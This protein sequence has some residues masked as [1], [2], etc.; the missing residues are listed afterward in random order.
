M[1]DFAI[2]GAIA[3]LPISMMFGTARIPLLPRVWC[4]LA[5]SMLWEVLCLTIFGNT[6]GKAFYRLRLEPSGGDRL[7]FV[8]AWKR[9]WKVFY[10]GLGFGVWFVIPISLPITLG[11]Y[12]ESGRMTWDDDARITVRERPVG[13][14]RLITGAMLSVSTT[15]LLCS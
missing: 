15:V 7:T 8:L 6:P 14:G 5:F 4:F 13:S 11:R 12:F 3:L 9:S 1:V 10:R 2:G